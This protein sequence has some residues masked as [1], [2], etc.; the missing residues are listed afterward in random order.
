MLK[1]IVIIFIFGVLGILAVGVFSYFYLTSSNP[2]GIEVAPYVI[3]D[4]Y[5]IEGTKFPTRYYYAEFIKIES[6]KAI[7][8][9]YWRFDG[10]RYHKEDDLKTIEPPFEIIRRAR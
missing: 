7:V 9:N 2:P 1:V 10:E 5:E 6:G 3:Q 8:E 4:Y